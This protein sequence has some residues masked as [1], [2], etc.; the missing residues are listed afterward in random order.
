M[1]NRLV[2]DKIREKLFKGKVIVVMG[3]RQVGKTTLVRSLVEEGH[4]PYLWLNADEIDVQQQ[5]T[6]A[7]S[8]KL[9]GIF[10]SYKIIVIDEAQRVRN[11]GLTLKIAADMLPEYQ[12]IATGSSAFELANE[13]VE[14][15]TGRKH[16]FHL[17]P[18]S[19]EEMAEGSSVWE[20]ARSIEHRLVYGW[21]PN[22]VSRQGSEVD[23]LSDLT[24][25]YLYKDILA[26][27][28]I[29]RPEVLVKLIQALA[30]Q[31]G[32]EVSYHE[33]GQTVGA[34]NQTV[35]RYI[36]LLERSFIIFR[37][38]ALRRNLRTELKKSRKIYFYD[39][40]VRNA[41]IRQYGP[42]ENRADRGALWE[43]FLVSERLKW[44]H[45]HGHYANRYFWRTLSQQEIDYVEEWGG[46]I[47]AFQ[48]KWKPTDKLALPE[49]FVKAYQVRQ[50]KVVHRE[51]FTEFVAGPRPNVVHQ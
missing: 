51:N 1:I 36:D 41:V 34:D 26:L 49:S 15:L 21:Y 2:L 40:G 14:P 44:L 39:N 7:T 25:S 4:G 23:I 24:G 50:S 6:D 12:V 46:A 37:L 16:E 38:S 9:K 8:P 30:L 35:E 29:K 3:P 31:A 47:D 5:L 22:V 45:Y 13:I 20:E 43:N 18:I 10:G 42:V 27:G 32:S 48:F 11:I 28:I 33:L 17:F 19:F